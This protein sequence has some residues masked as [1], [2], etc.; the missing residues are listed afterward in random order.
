[1]QSCMHNWQWPLAPIS[2][3][4]WDRGT[5]ILHAAVTIPWFG[6]ISKNL[7]LG[8]RQDIPNPNNSEN[9]KQRGVNTCRGLAMGIF[10][11]WPRLQI[12]NYVSERLWW[13]VF[14]RKKWHHPWSSLAIKQ[15]KAVWAGN[16]RQMSSS[17][18]LICFKACCKK[19]YT[20]QCCFSPALQSLARMFLNTRDQI[21][22][23]CN[24]SG[25]TSEDLCSRWA[26]L[27]CTFPAVLILGGLSLLSL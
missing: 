27:S 8:K 6:T 23:W 12:I 7:F 2:L 16:N 3:R 20:A 22:L 4:W 13:P 10:W 24:S 25:A 5:I 11:L 1:M 15:N 9:V 17:A 18:H 14:F 19:Y 26:G 21:N